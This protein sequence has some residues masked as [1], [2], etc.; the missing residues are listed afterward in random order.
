MN[1]I[2]LKIPVKSIPAFEEWMEANGHDSSE[3][4]SK[5]VTQLKAVVALH[6][7]D[8]HGTVSV[9][10]NAKDEKKLMLLKLTW[11]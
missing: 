9:R 10:V 7:D 8:D 11:G 1:S 4:W 5:V 2:A 6:R 3:S